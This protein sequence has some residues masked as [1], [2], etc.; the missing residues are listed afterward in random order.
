M[1]IGVES[2]KKRRKWNLKGLIISHLRKIFFYSPLRREAMEKAKVGDLYRS[3]GNGKK[4]PKD[5]MKVDHILPVVD[6]KTG[7]VDWN[8]FIDRL[9]CPVENLQVISKEEHEKK[10]KAEQKQRRQNKKN[11]AD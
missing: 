5:Q 4:Y 9:F 3:G 6:P 1:S 11:K 7:W 2:M 8:T 10:T